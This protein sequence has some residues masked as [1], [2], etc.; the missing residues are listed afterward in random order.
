MEEV[1]SK[2]I[3]R[4]IKTNFRILSRDPTFNSKMEMHSLKNR[5]IK[6]LFSKTNRVKDQVD[7]STI[8]TTNKINLPLIRI[9][10]KI[11]ASLSSKIS[12]NKTL[13]LPFFKIKTKHKETREAAFSITSNKEI[14]WT[15][16]IKKIPISPIIQIKR[17]VSFRITT[18]I[19]ALFSIQTILKGEI[20]SFNSP[21]T[22][23]L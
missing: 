11:I 16:K 23:T 10:V 22:R 15:I 8:T 12:H 6:A 7:S 18:K 3:N 13:S 20:V 17:K 5:V 21:K 19:R 4:T 9:K 2:T 14:R 1:F